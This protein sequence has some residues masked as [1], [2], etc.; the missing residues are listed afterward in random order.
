MFKLILTLVGMIIIF[1]ILIFS[2]PIF[3]IISFVSEGVSE[4]Q[5][6]FEEI[7]KHIEEFQWK[8]KPAKN[9]YDDSQ[10]QIF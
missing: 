3:Q 5:N 8:K 7:E 4:I 1:T 10:A 2:I 9:P 6:I